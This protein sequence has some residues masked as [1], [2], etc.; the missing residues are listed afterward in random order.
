MIYLLY[1]SRREQNMKIAA[2]FYNVDFSAEKYSTIIRG[3]H[4]SGRHK[5]L[6]YVD[7]FFVQSI[8][9]NRD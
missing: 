3:T 5:M 1:V 9:V 7:E 2:I 6:I 8:N 4:N